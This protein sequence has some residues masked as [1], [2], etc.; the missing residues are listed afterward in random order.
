MLALAFLIWRS[1]QS[2]K[3]EHWGTRACA[4]RPG[5]GVRSHP[6]CVC[7]ALA[8]SAAALVVG[9]GDDRAVEPRTD[10]A[11][12]QAVLDIQ[13]EYKSADNEAASARRSCEFDASSTDRYVD[14]YREC[15]AAK[16]RPVHVRQ[17]A[18]LRRGIGAL[19]PVVGVR[20]RAALRR[21]M[22]AE[23][24]V[25]PDELTRAH[26]ECLRDTRR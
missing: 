13:A 5:Q 12:V 8:M 25:Q 7:S 2:L 21:A 26:T 9:C 10:R 18:A 11:E 22:S 16:V 19:L 1:G 17:A 24:A 6:V 14:D 3:I 4:R 23:Y 20:C 15:F